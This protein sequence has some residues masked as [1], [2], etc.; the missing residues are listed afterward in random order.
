M[1]TIP[2]DKEE[3][4]K[5]IIEWKPP[6]KWSREDKCVYLSN[7]YKKEY[8]IYRFERRHGNQKNS[9]QNL[10]IGLAFHQV[11]D[12]RLHQGF[13]ENKITLEKGTDLFYIF[14]KINLSPFLLSLD[15]CPT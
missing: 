13:H 8:G 2:L 11:F 14:C 1:T 4:W 12:Q 10:Y 6:R 15:T 7:K 9:R 5:A 3:Y